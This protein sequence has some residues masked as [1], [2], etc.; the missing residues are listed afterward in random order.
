MDAA[1]PVPTIFDVQPDPEA[2]VEVRRLPRLTVQGL[3]LLGRPA[4][5]TC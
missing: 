3:R 1:E 5:A 4:A 2:K